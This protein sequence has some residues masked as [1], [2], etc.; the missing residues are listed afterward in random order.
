MNFRKGVNRKLI[1]KLLYPTKFNYLKISDFN[2]IRF[3][4]LCLMY[5]YK[6]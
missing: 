6:Y 5:L 2:L 3:E 4:P 1:L